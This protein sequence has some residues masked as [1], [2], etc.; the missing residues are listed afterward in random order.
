MEA[1]YK[2]VMTER[3][4]EEMQCAIC[5]ESHISHKT[6]CADGHT[7]CAGCAESLR[8]APIPRCAECRGDLLAVF[9][10]DRRV[11]Q[12][13]ESTV[14]A[15]QHSRGP[16]AKC[17]AEVKLSEYKAHLET[18]PGVTI[19]CRHHAD[20]GCA[21]TGLRADEEAQPPPPRH[22]V[23]AAMGKLLAELREQKEK[24]DKTNK[25]LQEKLVAQGRTIDTQTARLTALTIFMNGDGAKPA[26]HVHNTH[27]VREQLKAITAKM[28]KVDHN[29]RPKRATI[30]NDVEPGDRTKRNWAAEKKGLEKKQT[31]LK[32]QLEEERAETKRLKHYKTSMQATLKGSTPASRRAC[33]RHVLRLRRRAGRGGHLGRTRAPRRRR[34]PPHRRG[35]TPDAGVGRR[36][37]AGPWRLPDRLVCRVGAGGGH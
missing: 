12:L 36:R 31:D 5:Y 14:V 10:P 28:E 16:N 15:C 26:D 37:A 20:L 4:L 30:H 17:T 2:T 13:I 7:V 23:A 6:V 19:K 22:C 29:T 3:Q 27:C 24:Q 21:W 11:K 33:R 35:G 32:R 34:P 18:C 8:S 1:L 9:P 25:A